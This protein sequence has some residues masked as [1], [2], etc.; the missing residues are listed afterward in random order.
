MAKKRSLQSPNARRRAR[1]TVFSPA[2]EAAKQDAAIRWWYHQMEQEGDRALQRLN[3]LLGPALDRDTV[4]L[5]LVQAKALARA[6]AKA[7]EKGDA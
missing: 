2:A 7:Q 4:L 6:Q 1:A 3:A 5:A